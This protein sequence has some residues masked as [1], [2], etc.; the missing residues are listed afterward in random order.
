MKK[1]KQTLDN[2][3]LPPEV[4]YESYERKPYNAIFDRLDLVAEFKAGKDGIGA[5]FVKF[6]ESIYLHDEIAKKIDDKLD[7][8]DTLRKIDGKKNKIFRNWDSTYNLMNTFPADFADFLTLAPKMKNFEERLK[9]I[10]EPEQKAKAEMEYRRYNELFLKCS[11]LQEVHSAL[12]ASRN[13]R[14]EARAI[15]MT[16]EKELNQLRDQEVRIVSKISDDHAIADEKGLFVGRIF[17]QVHKGDILCDL[18]GQDV[19]TI[20]RY[21]PK[22]KAFVLNLHSYCVGRKS[23][24]PQNSS[25]YSNVEVA[26]YLHL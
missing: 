13:D 15:L 1:G 11:G 25:V 16:A 6:V 3:P 7:E 14:D 22:T 21:I 18:N 8:I 2:L 9:R 26:S 10:S 12:E 23:A 17:P 4:K 19:V 20:S 24:F 5:I